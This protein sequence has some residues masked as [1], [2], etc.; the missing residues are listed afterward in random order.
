MCFSNS[1]LFIK[2]KNSDKLYVI[3]KRTEKSMQKITIYLI[4]LFIYTTLTM[5][6]I[7]FNTVYKKKYISYICMSHV[8]GI[9]TTVFTLLGNLINQSFKMHNIAVIFFLAANFFM[10][11]AIKEFINKKL[12]NV[13]MIAAI[14]ITVVDLSSLIFCY[15]ISVFI[16]K[17]L[18]MS[19]YIRFGMQINKYKN[20]SVSLGVLGCS[21]IIFPLIQVCF[22]FVWLFVT[23]KN[24]YVDLLAYILL[25]LTISLFIILG[26]LEEAKKEFSTQVNELEEKVENKKQLLEDAYKLDKLKMEFIANISHD[27]RTPINIIFS[28]IQIFEVNFPKKYNCDEKTK[29][30][31]KVMKNNCYRLIKLI[32]NLIDMSKIE[33]GFFK[34]E[35]HNYDI[36]NVVEDLTM[37]IVPYAEEKNIQIE[38]DTEFEEKIIACDKEKIE[39]VLLNLLANA[40]KFTGNSGKIEVYLC[41][42]EGNIV[43]SIKDNGIGI[44]EE[45]QKFIY[46][47]FTR[48]EGKRAK[49]CEGSGIGLSLVKSLVEM[50]GGNIKLES[51]INKG[52]KFT[53]TIPIKTIDEEIRHSSYFEDVKIKEVEIEFSDINI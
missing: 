11:S 32:N 5:V 46:N 43:I 38:F 52:C 26:T 12:S 51:E 53:M 16:H 6:F 33:A 23:T 17:I 36:V 21:M 50:H 13:E 41:E 9:I 40:V 44:D 27:L 7:A 48:V 15:S 19:I 24:Y 3:I 30:Y 8:M 29:K 2:L 47:R 31:L 20:K 34:L 4:M 22:G 49:N 35:L 14:I 10:Y 45:M 37:S 42:K 1:F 18:L 39:R 25:T 28:S